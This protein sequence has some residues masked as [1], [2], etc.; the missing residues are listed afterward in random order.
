MAPVIHDLKADPFFQVKVCV[1]GQHRTMLDQVLQLFKI[2]AD[3][4]LD[5]MTP[6]QDLYG[7]TSEILL[8]LRKTLEELKPDMV[9]VHGDTTT[10]FAGSLASFYAK[11]PVGHVEAGLRTGNLLAPY[12]EEANRLLTTKLAELH[13]TPTATSMNNLLKESV[14]EETIIITG[15]TVVDALLIAKETVNS[16]KIRNYECYGSAENVLKENYPFVLITGHRRENFGTGFLGICN[17]V[18]KLAAEHPH[19]HFIYPVHLNPNVQKPVRQ[20]LGNHDNIHLLAPQ[21]YGPF[22]FLMDKCMFVLTDS[23]G[24]QEEAPSLNKPVLVMRNTTERPEALATGAVTLVGTDEAVIIEEAVK[25]IRKFDAGITIPA[26]ENPYGDGKAAARIRSA[27]KQ[28]Y[29]K[30]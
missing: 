11:I 13:F 5:I 17:A 12:P 14:K 29:H 4:D 7:V 10:C 8:G 26:Q 9:L 18:A 27:L 20:R 23:G 1:T 15:N 24:I 28:W 2:R 21:E 19:V 22:I 25:L 3:V 6:N 16:E 30:R